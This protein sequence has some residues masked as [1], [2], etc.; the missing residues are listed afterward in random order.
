MLVFVTILCFFQ[1]K[2]NHWLNVNIQKSGYQSFLFCVSLSI[3]IASY[4]ISS[5]ASLI[6]CDYLR[7]IRNED[8][9][10]KSIEKIDLKNNF[11]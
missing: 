2:N 7:Q 10:N 1:K 8:A 4:L 9:E 6:T 11:K 5:L 3:H